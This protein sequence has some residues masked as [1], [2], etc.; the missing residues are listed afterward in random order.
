MNDGTFERVQHTDTPMYGPKKLILCGFPAA[1]QDKFG[2]V[3]EMAGL[4]GVPVIWANSD[5]QATSLAD[6]LA[7]PADS[8]RGSDST[9]PRAVIVAGIT[10]NQL[11]SLMTTCRK[12]GMQQALWAVLTPTS[13]TWPLSGLLGELQAEKEA[14]SKRKKS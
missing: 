3:L 13:E 2:L 12:T 8:G 9:L 14:L 10:E 1:V 11:H 5:H 4:R 7:L 6:L